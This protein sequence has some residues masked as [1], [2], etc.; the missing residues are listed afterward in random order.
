M[1]T[2]YPGGGGGGKEGDE[3]TKQDVLIMKSLFLS[4]EH[5]FNKLDVKGTCAISS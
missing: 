1:P 2:F 3:L 5:Q 4:L